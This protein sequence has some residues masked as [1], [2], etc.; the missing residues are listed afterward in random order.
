M[1]FSK[2]CF[3]ITLV[4][5]VALTGVERFAAQPG[6]FE[7]LTRNSQ[8][9]Y[10]ATTDQLHPYTGQSSNEFVRSN[11]VLH[12][13]GEKT[14]TVFLPVQS[15]DPDDLATG[16]LLVASPTL[17]DPDFAETVILLVHCDSD[18]VIGLIVNRR[19][20][21]PLSRVLEQFAAAKGRSDPVYL[22][23]PVQTPAV[24]AL[25]RSTAKLEG[26]KQILSGVYWISTK[27]LF[28]KAISGKPGPDSF[29]VYL[30]YAGWSDDQLRNEV[31]LGAWFIFQ[32]DEEAIFNSDPDSL[33][34]LMIQKT[35]L[36]LATSEPA[37]AQIPP[38]IR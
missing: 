2:P 27:T 1:S 9:Y 17:T 24:F 12:A 37:P 25:L 14:S 35:E 13:Q 6:K 22:G 36:K 20:N 29:H 4:V 15:K 16:R 30:G 11:L 31:Q 28:E 5:V 33:W 8:S 7:A 38:K 23:G 21:V 26:A 34:R 3:L 18:G 10:P 32:G 19:T